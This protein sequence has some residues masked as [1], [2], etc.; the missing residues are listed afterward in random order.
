M[1]N[2]YD[3]NIYNNNWD[4]SGRKKYI[5]NESLELSAIIIMSNHGIE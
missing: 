4:L 1:Q 3:D 5:L 2:F